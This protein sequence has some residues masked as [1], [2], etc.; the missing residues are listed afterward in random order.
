VVFSLAHPLGLL[1]L[2]VPV[3]AILVWLRLPPPLNRGRARLSLGLR[4]AIL[5][6]LVLALS[7][8]QWE[9][10]PQWQ[11]WYWPTAA[12]AWAVAARPSGKRC[13]S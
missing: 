2:V 11:T 8:L 12:P 5:L 9:R 7:G 4:L 6:C 3:L 1:A 10:V 13:W